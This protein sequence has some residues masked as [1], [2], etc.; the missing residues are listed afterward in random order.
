[1]DHGQRVQK[2]VFE[3]TLSP[4]DWVALR[5][6]LVSIMDPNVDSIRFYMLHE[7]VEIVHLGASKP[8]DLDGPLVV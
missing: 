6:K 2:S 3:C 4:V 1:M 8:D 7:D 5:Y